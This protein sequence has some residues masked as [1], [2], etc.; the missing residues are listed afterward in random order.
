LHNHQ[1]IKGVDLKNLKFNRIHSVQTALYGLFAMRN[2]FDSDDKE[3]L[4]E[5]F[6][7]SAT[8]TPLV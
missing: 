4:A 3:I 2:P 5:L 8:L 7:F 6:A 1:T